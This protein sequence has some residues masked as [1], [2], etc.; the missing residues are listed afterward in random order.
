MSHQNH[1]PQGGNTEN[2]HKNGEEKSPKYND[3]GYWVENFDKYLE[4][5][6]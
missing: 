2:L 6:Q 5:D 3:A 1:L 4:H